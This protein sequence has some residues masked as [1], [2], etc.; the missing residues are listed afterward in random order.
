MIWEDNEQISGF[1][2]P[3]HGKFAGWAA[4]MFAAGGRR[5]RQRLIRRDVAGGGTGDLVSLQLI[6]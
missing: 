1:F 6:A 3:D 5:P 2:L 4:G